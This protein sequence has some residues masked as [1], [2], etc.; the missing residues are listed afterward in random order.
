MVIIPLILLHFVS[1]TA[2]IFIDRSELVF[3][4]TS[5]GRVKDLS[6]GDISELLEMT[7][8]L[9]FLILQRV[10]NSLDEIYCH[11]LTDSIHKEN[12]FADS[13]AYNS[14]LFWKSPQKQDFM[15]LYTTL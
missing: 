11:A 3:I 14:S 15:G 7:V 6:S 13:V 2:F 12:N 4:M 5:T 10:E 1:D 8:H 9:N